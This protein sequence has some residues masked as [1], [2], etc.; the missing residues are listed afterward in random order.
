MRRS[1]RSFP[2][3]SN[4]DIPENAHPITPVGRG[5]V[6]E[7]NYETNNPSRIVRDAPIPTRAE[8]MVARIAKLLFRFA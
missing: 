2:E 4:S 3:R 5:V 8:M 6:P 7:S 1:C